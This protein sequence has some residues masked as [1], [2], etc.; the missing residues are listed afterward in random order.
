MSDSLTP[1]GSL[2]DNTVGPLVSKLMSFIPDGDAQQKAM[3]AVMEMD[4]TELKA[5]ID[6]NAIEAA[7]EKWWKA[8][9]RPFFGWM[10]GLGFAYKFIISPLIVTVILLFNEKYPVAI[11]PVV[12]WADMSPMALALLGISYN[13]TTEKMGIVNSKK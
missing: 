13:R 6:I 12:D 7:S 4:W 2:I 5:Q 9:W 10:C 8:G 3:Q 1:W 11:L